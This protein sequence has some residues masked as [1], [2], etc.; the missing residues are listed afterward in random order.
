MP[1]DHQYL[2]TLFWISVVDYFNGS[3]TQL[4][5][6]TVHFESQYKLFNILK[7]SLARVYCNVLDSLKTFFYRIYFL[8]LGSFPIFNFVL[9]VF[10]EPF[11]K[12][13]FSSLFLNQSAKITGPTFLRD[14]YQKPCESFKITA[15]NKKNKAT[16]VAQIK[17]R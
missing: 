13:Y 9:N 2:T 15:Q 8:K 17:P 16:W 7:F 10:L 6:K 14:F 4:N 5:S 11:P 3:K 12:L 1:Y